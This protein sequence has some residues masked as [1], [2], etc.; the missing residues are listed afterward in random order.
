MVLDIQKLTV[1]VHNKQV[2][3]E[4]SLHVKKQSLHVIMGPNG[5]GKSTLARTLLGD[6]AVSVCSGTIHF[7]N[8][9][10]CAMQPHER[11][12]CGLFVSYQTPIE[13]PGVTMQEFLW[14]STRAVQI[15]RGETLPTKAAFEKELHEKME[16]LQIPEAFLHRFVHVGFSGG[17]KKNSEVLQMLLLHPEVAVLDEIDSGLDVDAIK[18]VLT[19]LQTIRATHTVC[20]ITHNIHFAE[21]VQ[22]DVVHIL[23]DGTIVQTGNKSLIQTVQ[24]KGYD[25]F[26]GH[27]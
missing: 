10:L 18:R 24:K 8:K 9:N 23:C 14:L 21:L 5:A 13:I 22:P 6:P 4:L 15:L 16:L 11:V 25:H 7:C 12:G 20:I 17:E 26:K 1:A 3:N 27:Q 19:T 2:L